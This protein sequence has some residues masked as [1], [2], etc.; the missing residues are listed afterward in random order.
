M[1]RS[2]PRLFGVA[3]LKAVCACKPVGGQCARTQYAVQHVSQSKSD[4]ASGG[5][6]GCVPV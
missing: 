1:P 4:R 3:V 6:D 5:I 2:Y